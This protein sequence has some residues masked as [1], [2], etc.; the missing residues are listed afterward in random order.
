MNNAVLIQQIYPNT[1][2]VAMLELTRA[3]HKAYCDKWHMD[4]WCKFENPQEEF[5]PLKGSWG[6]IELIR[7]AL[8]E[9]YE[10]VFWLDADT[11]IVDFETDLRDAVQCNKIGACWHRIP[12]MNHW[13]VGALYLD[14][15]YAT[16]TFINE[17]RK[18]YPGSPQWMEQGEFNRLARENRTVVTLSDKWNATLDVNIVPDAVVLGFHG[19]GDTAYRVK[20]MQQ[21]MERLKILEAV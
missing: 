5:D 2:G 17:W 10:Y 18:T 3:H 7:C 14:N 19:Q 13:N 6:K 11:L 8:D 16:R 1:P 12:Q 20:L 9:G 4:Y 15:E 21:A